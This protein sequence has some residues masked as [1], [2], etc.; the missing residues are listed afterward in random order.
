MFKL[1]KKNSGT[2]KD[3]AW[4]VARIKYPYTIELPDKG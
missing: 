1:V 2:S 3:W 4:G